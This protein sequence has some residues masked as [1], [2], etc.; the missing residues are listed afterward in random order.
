MALNNE[1]IRDTMFTWSLNNGSLSILSIDPT[2]IDIIRY[3]E[4]K[5]ST[6]LLRKLVGGHDFRSTARCVY[7]Y[8]TPESNSL[9]QSLAQL[10][11]YRLPLQGTLHS[12]QKTKLHPSAW[13]TSL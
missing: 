4:I 6:V 1:V 5:M 11:N 9:I 2:E 13:Q 10:N 3:K 8:F 12:R 7:Q